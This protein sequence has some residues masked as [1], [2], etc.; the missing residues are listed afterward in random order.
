MQILFRETGKKF[1]LGSLVDFTNA[2][3][4]LPFTHGTHPLRPHEGHPLAYA[5]IDRATIFSLT[6]RVLTWLT[7]Y[8]LNRYIAESVLL[9]PQYVAQASG[10]LSS[11]ISVSNKIGLVVSQTKPKKFTDFAVFY[12]CPYPGRACN[13]WTIPM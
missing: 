6:G 8:N 2:V 4:Q 9:R 13:C 12:F 1:R 10:V 7:P 3:Y 5:N 11:H